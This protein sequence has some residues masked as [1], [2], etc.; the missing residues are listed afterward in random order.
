MKARIKNLFSLPLLIAGL[1]LILNG[2]A[3]AQT[4]S[5]LHNFSAGTTNALGFFT[6]SDGANPYVSL[7]W[8]SNFLYGTAYAGCSAGNGTIFAI[9]TDGTGFT[10]LYRFTASPASAYANIYTNSDGASP[11]ADL[12]LAG[13]MLFGTAGYGGTNGNGTVFK[14]KTDGSGF[15]NLY[16]FKF[17]YGA[18][19][20]N[21]DGAL[22][23]ASL[24]LSGG[25]L[26][27]TASAGGTNGNGTVFAVSTN[28]TGF[29]TLHN[30]TLLAGMLETNSDGANPIAGLILAGNTL[31]GTATAG[32]RSGNGAIFALNTNGT[33]FTN[34]YSFT[35][36]N[37]SSANNDGATPQANL[38]LS[39]GTLYGV[40]SYGGT[41]GNGTVFALNTNGTGFTTLHHFSAVTTNALGLFTNSDGA[42]P[43]VL[44]LSGNT[45]YGTAVNGGTNGNGIVFAINT[46]GTGFMNLFSFMGGS[47]AN[48]WGVTKAG[49]TLYG[50]ASQGGTHGVGTVFSLAYPSPQLAINHSGTNVN[51]T[52]PSG[53]AGFSY[54]TYILQSATNLVS[55]SVWSNVA[56]SPVVVSGQNTVTNPVSGQQMFFRLSQSFP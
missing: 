36:T 29:T 24:V 42:N 53:V 17:T 6:N 47:G 43:A 40:A 33:G 13:N 34:L 19:I 49:N 20:T 11:A 41:N 10:N 31:Y 45:L 50:T 56:T 22:P 7:V 28:G 25:T 32:G 54:G 38:I 15:G 18:L 16:N 51:V 4:F 2:R 39:G 55:P 12:I 3:T 35:A 26:Y 46:N 44:F 27:G 21:T 9:N 5:T 23:A 8:S 37:A 48:P 14:V 1:G 30:F 52:W